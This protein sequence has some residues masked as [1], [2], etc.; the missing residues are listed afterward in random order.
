M[1]SAVPV[2]LP[3][4]F[5]ISMAKGSNELAENGLLVSRLSATED[6]ATLTTLCIDK[7]GTTF[8]KNELSLE[9]TLATPRFSPTDVVM[10]GTMASVKADNDPIDLALSGKQKNKN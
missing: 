2:G 4:M 6:A 3:A 8:T 1:V 7:T 5:T 9:Q 10:F